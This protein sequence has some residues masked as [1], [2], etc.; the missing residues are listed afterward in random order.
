MS[1]IGNILWFVLG[2]LLIGLGYIIAGL[3]FCLT[4]IGIPFGYQLIKIGFYTF[5][6]FGKDPSFGESEPSCLSI[7]F[8]I[9]WITLGWWEIALT[10]VIVGLLLCLTVIGIPFGLQHFKIAKLSFLPFGQS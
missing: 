8:N 5:C 10:H 4:I 9:L 3:I 6:P 1:L 2:G 7:I